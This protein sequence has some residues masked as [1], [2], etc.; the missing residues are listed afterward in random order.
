MKNLSLWLRLNS[1]SYYVPAS[2]LF[3]V[4]TYL[5]VYCPEYLCTCKCT[6]LSIYVLASVLFWVSIY[7]QVYCPEYLCTCTCTV[8]SIYVPASVLSWVLRS[9]AHEN[10]CEHISFTGD[11]NSICQFIIK[12]FVVPEIIK[13][14][15][16]N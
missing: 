2:V 11:F 15:C 5:Q 6:V 7:L 12:G 1:F 10:H 4:S 9:A 16:K 8:L 13:F 14:Y 3:W